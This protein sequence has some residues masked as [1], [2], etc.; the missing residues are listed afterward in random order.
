MVAAANLAAEA[1][2]WRKRNFAG[3]G[4]ALG[5][6]AAAWRRQQQRSSGSGS[7]SSAVAGS[8]AMAVT[9]WRQ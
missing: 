7:V 9:A 4:S 1:A 5:S 3:G 8:L 2:A 6:T